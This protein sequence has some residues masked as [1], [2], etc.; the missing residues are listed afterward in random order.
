M[1]WLP[2]R[3][4]GTNRPS[5]PMSTCPIEVY[6]VQMVHLMVLC[7][8]ERGQVQSHCPITPDSPPP[9]TVGQFCHLWDPS[10]GG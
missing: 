6:T 1:T 8:R 4:E 7:Q 9:Y 10:L 5:F 2:S 3:R